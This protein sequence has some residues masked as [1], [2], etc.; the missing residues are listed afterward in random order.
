M[1]SYIG[2]STNKDI[3]Y[4]ASSGG[5]GSS[6]I[7]W[8]FESNIVNTAIAFDYDVKSIKYHP[9]LIYSFDEY[10]ISGSIYQ[11]I[12]LVNFIKLHIDEIKGNFVC[13]ALPCQTRTIRAIIES[14]GHNAIIIG[15]AC[16]SQQTIKATKYLIKRL[17]INKDDI[18]KL[19]YRGNGWPSG[20]QIETKD[21]RKVFIANNSSLWTKIF[22]SRLFIRNRCFMCKDTLNKY[23]DI[24]LADPWLPYFST[25]KIGKTLVVCNTPKGKELLELC[26]QDGTIILENIDYEEIVKSQR[27]TILRKSSYRY[28]PILTKYYKSILGNKIYQEVM[29]IPILFSIHCKFKHL[30]EKYLLYRQRHLK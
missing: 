4:K 16:S 1:K 21:G 25:E 23:S 5:V 19:Q 7:K 22:H 17:E 29:L 18:N 2:Y 14:A 28:S 24:T 15:L 11:E 20:V 10:T 6:L 30:I 12:D 9:K 8:M 26:A 3:R 13:F 27:S